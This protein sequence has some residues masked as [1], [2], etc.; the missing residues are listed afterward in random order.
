M[1]EKQTNKPAGRRCF[2]R[3][4]PATTDCRLPPQPAAKV[5]G[6]PAGGLG[7]PLVLR[8]A[9]CAYDLRRSPSP[10]VIGEGHAHGVPVVE[11]V[12]PGQSRG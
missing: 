12:T 3:T 2:P 5:F 10:R 7:L 6:D 11:R 4:G 9:G 1:A 8:P